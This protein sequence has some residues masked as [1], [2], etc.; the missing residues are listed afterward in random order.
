MISDSIKNE[1]FRNMD[2]QEIDT[3]SYTMLLKYINELKGLT[4]YSCYF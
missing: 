2:V 4:L 3:E 1:I